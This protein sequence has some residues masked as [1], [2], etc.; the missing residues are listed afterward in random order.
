MNLRHN[1]PHARPATRFS[2]FFR[3]LVF[4]PLRLCVRTLLLVF[5]ANQFA[6]PAFAQRNLTNI[7]DPDPE[8]ER[9]SF[10]VADGFEVNLFAADPLLAKPIQMNFDAAGRL[11]VAS[12]EVYPQIE[13]G[14]TANDKIIVLEDTD[15]DGRA[16]KTTV[17][18]DGLLIPTGIE[19]DAVTKM[20]DGRLASSA[21][22]ANS[23]ELL[24]LTDT[25]GD[26]RA[27]S[28]RIVLSGFGTEDTHHILHTLRW[29]HDGCLYFNQS[30]YIHS[31]IET[32]WGVRR[33]G[34]GGIWQFR[35]ESARLE[36][37][38]RG[39]VNPWGH[40]FDDWGQS[41]ATD[42]AYG[43][44]IN[45]VFP[46]ATFFSAPGA[47]R[48]LKGLNPG[49]PKHCG[50]EIVGGR[51]LPD[52]WQGN[53]LTNDFRGNRVCRFVVSEDGSGFASREMPELIKT[54]HVAF[55]PIDIK[56]G[57]D[58]AI[59]IADWY[60]PI[61]QHGEVDFRDP[62]RDHT[63]GRIWRVTAKG[64]PL[65]ERP[66][67]VGA[68]VE[69]LLEQLKSPEPWTRH[70][71]KRVLKERRAAEVV[72]A[73]K[74]WVERLDQ[75]DANVQHHQ[76]D[77]LWTFQSLDVVDVDLLN[78][79]L[80][81]KDHRAR[82]AA[83]RVLSDWAARLDRPLGILDR[84]FPDKHARVRLEEVRALSKH[85]HL[86]SAESAMLVLDQPMD[87]FLDFALWQTMRDLGPIW[88]PV[89]QQA[90]RTD[91]MGFDGNGRDLVFALKAIGSPEVVRPLV[92]LLREGKVPAE[93]E[94]SVLSLVG[95]Q[96]GPAELGMVF[97][98]VVAADETP[99]GRRV[100]LLDSL[101]KATRQR[102]VRPDGDL[103]RLGGLL[104]DGHDVHVRAAA[105]RAAGLW[106]V[107]SLRGRLDHLAS[108]ADELAESAVPLVP[109]LRADVRQAAMDGI[110]LLGGD[111]S[112]ASLGK[113]SAPGRPF[114]VR[115][116]AVAAL[117]AVDLKSAAGRAAEVLADAKADSDASKIFRSFL[118]RKAGPAALA[119]ALAD[120]QIPA[121]VAK[122]GIRVASISGRE[123][124]ELVSALTK[125]GQLSAGLQKLTPDEL[126]AMARD[127]VELGDAA[128]GEDI[129]R[130]K[131]LDCQ[132]CHA[133]AGAGGLVGPDLVSIGASAQI[134]Y[135][136]DSLVDPA[137]QVK[138]GFHS[139]IVATRDGRVLNGIKVRQADGELVL[140][141]A[142]N[143]EVAIPLGNV[144][145]QKP[146]GSLMPTGL[147]D[148]LTRGELV[149]LVRFLSLLGK[150][151]TPYA[152][153]P[154]RVAR[155]WLVPEL[156]PESE[157]QIRHTGLDSIA[158]GSLPL[159]WTP[160]TAKVSGVLPL[161]EL[162]A[163]KIPY[164]SVNVTLARVELS[165]TTAGKVKLVLNSP[166]GLKLWLDQT[167]IEPRADLEFDLPVGLHAVTFAA[168]AES[169]RDGLRF[170]LQDVPGAATQ[171]QFVTERK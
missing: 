9:K 70:F 124:P 89:V 51:H 55:R 106:K 158:N 82:A 33:L 28:S 6:A 4:A 155:R 59:Y 52:D 18:A 43:E 80:L 57:P 149:D 91:E 73:L 129:Y 167:S 7:P 101:M 136:I 72:P 148:P 168:N 166:V 98:L 42:G 24:H 65:V 84:N 58:G 69:E 135:L 128:R 94:E 23:T 75:G 159:R 153:S 37:F 31:H 61:I 100:N 143:R 68:S 64:R 138:E 40:H 53:M 117:A 126:Q 107:E 111:A 139:L 83:N 116:M 122:I 162:P 66:R 77:A 11:W 118:E 104:D 145:E 8:I 32:P 105:A 5:I 160:V 20:N 121:D 115:R 29:G 92:V 34:G 130:R 150:T 88:L 133:I 74:E 151:D 22:V 103:A 16:D 97:D 13:P 157:K 67:L 96:G 87:P 154:A 163:L 112:R 60:N 108:G 71:A 21:F 156:T 86:N 15:G 12:S 2:S 39:F 45:Y 110:A 113:L 142:E 90:S 114:A 93:S 169:R 25:D 152:V 17:F 44:G 49:S 99:S 50:L 63:H 36:V 41:F 141:D 85:R 76:L 140:R 1:G 109:D 137:K 78:R 95:S 132:K 62:R 123:Q 27:D 14:K 10:Q 144:E 79:L 119:A 3:S 46:G 171:V 161:A 35:P 146:G 170:E 81:A 125:A 102:Q 164:Q 26:G 131:G 47:T 19:S 30:I 38:C 48:I 147:I 120:R 56:M 54:S 165:V 127:V 134:D